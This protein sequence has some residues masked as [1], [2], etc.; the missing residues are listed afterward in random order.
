MKSF[1]LDRKAKGAGLEQLGPFGQIKIL[2]IN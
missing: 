1:T 2:D